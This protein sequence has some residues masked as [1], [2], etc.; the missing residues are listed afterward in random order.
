LERS[1]ENPTK[2]FALIDYFVYEQ[3]CDDRDRLNQ[4]RILV[5]CWMTFTLLTW[6]AGIYFLFSDLNKLTIIFG[7]S[8]TL[9]IGSIFIFLLFSLKK[10]GNF[11][12]SANVTLATVCIFL[13][14]GVFLSSGPVYSPVTSLFYIPTVMAYLLVGRFR[15]F[16]WTLAIMTELG[17]L[18]LLEINGFNFP[19]TI[20]AQ[21]EVETRLIVSGLGF[22]AVLSLVL[23]YDFINQHLRRE[24]DL[25]HERWVFLAN[26][27]Q[28][29]EL[30]NR[31]R[32]DNMLKKTILT[33]ERRTP[34]KIVALVYLDLDGFK[35]INDQHGHHIGDQVLQAIAQRLRESLRE[36]DLIARQGGD[37]F[38]LML[39]Q[40]QS[41]NAVSPIV[42]KLLSK[43][44]EPIETTI[45]R[46]SVTGSIGVA[47]YPAHTTD[48]EELKIFA[49]QAMY[50][51]KNQGVGWRMYRPK[52]GSSPI[53]LA[54]TKKPNL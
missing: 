31:T 21:H 30:A 27:D 13:L 43:I 24:R 36:T 39:D 10:R 12:F 7:S 33:H 40:L 35:Q 3:F 19:Y 23:V 52:E 28:L 47:L 42:D 2:S 50:Q 15:G 34:G 11:L 51:A 45:D 37:E 1:S 25:E 48:V 20:D 49:D 54:Y 9:S 17:L 38:T 5:G 46:V 16:L 18:V 22:F 41:E 32:F 4:A 6:T 14:V 29:T 8:L 26:H 44:A 53:S